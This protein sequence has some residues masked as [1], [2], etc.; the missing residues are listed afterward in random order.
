VIDA[1]ERPQ[2]AEE[3]ILGPRVEV[4]TA[5]VLGDETG[6]PFEGQLFPF[7]QPMLNAVGSKQLYPPY[8]NGC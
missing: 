5:R 6:D 3:A 1:A 8:I 7:F 2:R 4:P